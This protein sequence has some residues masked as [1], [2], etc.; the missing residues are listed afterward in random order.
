VEV[1][2]VSIDPIFA[3]QFDGQF[4]VG[5]S[6]AELNAVL[7]AF[8]STERLDRGRKVLAQRVNDTNAQAKALTPQ[9]SALEESLGVIL[10]HR[11]ARG[12]L[13]T[14]Q[15]EIL[16]KTVSE[17][18]SK[19]QATE[20]SLVEASSKPRGPFIS[21]LYSVGRL[22]AYK[23]HSSTMKSTMSANEEGATCRLS[24]SS[25]GSKMRGAL[26]KVLAS[27]K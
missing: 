23:S 12:L 21:L 20:H 13:L 1:N 10:F 15:G 8:A 9:I 18:V 7:N 25:C 14:E 19:L 24:S 16:F 11:H 2:G 22:S 4:L 5:S 26:P 6:P 17:M 27:S 3:G